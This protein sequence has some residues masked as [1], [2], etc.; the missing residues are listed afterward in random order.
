[1]GLR[2]LRRLRTAVARRRTVRSL[3]R[4]VPRIPAPPPAAPAPAAAD[5]DLPR[6]W[7][8]NPIAEGADPCVVRD[9]ASYLWVQSVGDRAIVI[10]RSDRLT[11]LGERRVVWSAPPDGPFCA[12]VWAPEL[13][14]LDD[15]WHIYFAASDGDNRRHRTFV[16]VA[17]TDDPMGPYTVHGPLA[18]GDADGE[19]QWAIDLT[20]L[21][22]AGRRYAI[23][24]GWPGPTD[25]TQHLYIA[26]MASPTTLAGP[27]VRIS[28]AGDH[29]WERVRADRPGGLNEAPQVVQ[30]AG[31]TFLLYSASH[32]W[33][34]TYRMGLLE[35]TG[36]D[37][38]D[39]R[40]WRKH[41]EPVFDPTTATPGVG[42]GM[43]VDTGEGDRSWL[44]FHR[45]IDDDTS[46]RRAIHL[47]PVAWDPDGWPDLGTPTPAGL[48]RPAP[49]GTPTST[50]SGSR[51]WHFPREPVSRA[52]DYY[53]HQQLVGEDR[54]GL[55]LG[56]VPE[57]PVNAYRSGEKV[58]LRDGDY[59]D[60]TVSAMLDLCDGRGAVGLLLRTTAPAVGPAAQRGYFLGYDAGAASLVIVRTDGRAAHLLA[61]HPV[62]DPPAGRFRLVAVALGD[63]L[64]VSLTAADTRPAGT[65]TTLRARDPH[66]RSGSIGVRVD[67]ADACLTEL[68]VRPIRSGTGPQ[69]T[70]ENRST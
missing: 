25:P 55:H 11:S 14:R 2:P 36:P 23:W 17:D 19:P 38:L 49:A 4:G 61:R 8:V 15:R 20:V 40:S 31:R 26:A 53:G 33:H 29:P 18:T 22:H 21:E 37:P 41:R 7:F 44:V 32:A 69:P 66:Y 30:H 35:L 57:A 54:D 62:S 42:H 46:F 13:V 24:S 52:F 50:V 28:D 39:A 58:V 45:K 9:G 48:P 12:E 65:A 64:T 6:G 5:E 70:A 56:V 68:E 59:S 43:I 27:R 60:V 16:L 67:D 47:E 63:A 51:S 10:G 1:M 3:H 34:P